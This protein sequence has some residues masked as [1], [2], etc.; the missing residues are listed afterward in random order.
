M[1]LEALHVLVRELVVLAVLALF[2]ELLLPAGDMRRYVR[3]VFGLLVIVAVVQ[4]AA[5]PWRGLA[6][7][8]SALSVQSV[9]AAGD[10]LDDGRRLWEE[11]Q[12][13]AQAGYRDGL[14]KQ[15]KALAAFN[16]HLEVRHVEVRLAEGAEADPGAIEEVLLT[17]AGKSRPVEEVRIGEGDTG[18]AFAK[19]E[20][21]G[22]RLRT[23]IAGFYNLRL[24]QVVISYER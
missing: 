14:A 18:G 9:P 12:A 23:V 10:A 20:E 4:A 2:L 3:M 21:E 17:V 7:E 22:E 16:P 13:R 24:E 1:D 8:F 5:G 6:Q 11:N 19:Q 15:I